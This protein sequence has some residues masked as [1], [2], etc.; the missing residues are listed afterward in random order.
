MTTPLTDDRPPDPVPVD[1]DAGASVAEV[2]GIS[3]PYTWKILYEG[4]DLLRDGYPDRARAYVTQRAPR[5]LDGETWDA[6]VTVAE[7]VGRR[8][9]EDGAP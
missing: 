2:L 9:A 6:I 3:D 1:V 5:T 4:L 8:I 7:L